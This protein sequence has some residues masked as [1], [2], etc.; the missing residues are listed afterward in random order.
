MT[1]SIEV[2]FK[3][4]ND[5]ESAQAELRTLKVSQMYIEE[6]PEDANTTLFVPFF[7]TNV[8]S[9]TAGLG[10]VSPAAPI[11]SEVADNSPGPN[12]PSYLLYVEVETEDYDRVLTILEE[13][14]CYMRDED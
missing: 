12:Y 2:F 1:E 14:D 8:D 5:A 9:T 11:I 3:N 13:H 6:M 7:P 4:E 10:G